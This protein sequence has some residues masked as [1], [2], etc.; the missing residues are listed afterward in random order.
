[1]EKWRQAV[2]KDPGASAHKKKKT[3]KE[4]GEEMRCGGCFVRGPRLGVLYRE[5]PATRR[6]GEKGNGGGEVPREN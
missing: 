5:K 6:K 1:M 4:E 2:G 3:G